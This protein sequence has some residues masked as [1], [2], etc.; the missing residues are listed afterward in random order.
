MIYIYTTSAFSVYFRKLDE[1]PAYKVSFKESTRAK[2]KVR[3][4]KRHS[5][6]KQEGNHH[7]RI[8]NKGAYIQ[9]MTTK[10]VLSFFLVFSAL[11]SLVQGS[12]AVVVT[13]DSKVLAYVI[14]S[15]CPPSW[16][17]LSNDN[18]YKGR[19]IKGWNSE[20]NIGSLSGS[21]ISN[22]NFP[23][24]KHPSWS[25]RLYFGDSQRTSCLNIFSASPKM[26][27]DGA[28]FYLTNS[29][30]AMDDRHPRIQRKSS[31][32]HIPSLK[33]PLCRRH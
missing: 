22:N 21:A 12:M 30:S 19:L 11:L 13:G 9:K 25:R 1:T 3:I 5:S 27:D 29:N 20:S 10:V 28:E 16:N 33:A 24:H 2:Y 32:S 8:A 23:V 31:F 15:G 6:S 17:D 14:D 7:H 26:V 4:K 18:T